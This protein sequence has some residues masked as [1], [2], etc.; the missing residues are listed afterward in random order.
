MHGLVWMRVCGCFVCTCVYV[1]VP[2]MCEAKDER[3]G[4]KSYKQR[5]KADPYTSASTHSTTSE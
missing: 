2:F 4:N 5:T 1:S 3:G